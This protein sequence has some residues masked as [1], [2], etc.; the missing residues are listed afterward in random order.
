MALIVFFIYNKAMTNPLEMIE[1]EMRDLEARLTELQRAYYLDSRSLVSDQQYDKLFDR[2]SHLEELYPQF[3]APDSPTQRV[4][5]DLNSDFPEFRHTIP[6]LSLD[7]AYSA[8][9]VL[10]WFSKAQAKFSNNLSFVL[11]EKI[12][13][14]S[15]VLYYEKGLLMHAVTRGNGIIGNEVTQNIKTMPSIPLR[16]NE[17]IDLVARGEVYLG[18]ADFERLNSEKG[19]DEAYA[20]PRN[21]AAGAVRR[22]KSSETARIPLSMFVYEGFWD[23]MESTDHI[24]I[25]SRLKA[26]GLPTNPHIAYFSLNAS[27]SRQRLDEAGLNEMKALGFSDIEQYIREKTEQRKALPYEIDGLVAKV[28]EIRVREELGYTEHHPRW[29]I[30]YKFEAPQAETVVQSIEIQVGRTGRVTPVARVQKANV[31]GADIQR[32][33]LHNQQ[34]INELELAIGDTVSISRRGD[35]IPAVESVTE[36]NNLGNTT[37]QMPKSCPF[38]GSGLVKIG[39]HHFCP[40]T[41][42]KERVKQ[43]LIF[44]CDRSQ[45]DIE[46]LSTKTIEDLIKLGLIKDVPD[47]YTCDFKALLSVGGYGE[48]S[49]SLLEKAVEKSRQNPYVKVLSS[50]G[51][52]EIGKKAAST[53]IKG[54][55]KDIDSL[56]E[57]ASSNAIEKV[58]AIDQ[59]GEKT[60]RSL[61]DSLNSPQ[62]RQLIDELRNQGLHFSEEEKQSDLEQIFSGQA[63]CITGSLDSFSSRELAEAEIEKRGGKA[64]SSVSSRT[65]VLLA[66]KNAGSK[67][68]KARELGVK[69]VSEKEFLNLIGMDAASPIEPDLF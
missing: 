52:P 23:G 24:A 38:C 51:L 26:L 64:V 5:S 62:M 27:L 11:E 29:A 45:M 54:G 1:Q 44:F 66:G 48:R 56:L 63:W 46:G 30:A 42:C 7:K 47:I 40:N 50:L 53:L 4:G 21:L 67:L 16:L 28:N 65:S 14:I 3:K 34:Y 33:T 10:D 8:Q 13:G 32:I 36:K 20:N 6:V 2:L 25:L 41:Q 37:Y 68:D 35:V 39:A 57:A 59:M 60:A 49:V 19:E 15:M 69:I 17:P 18:K 22:Q 61:F 31:G 43:K 9:T 55:F 58:T 12:D